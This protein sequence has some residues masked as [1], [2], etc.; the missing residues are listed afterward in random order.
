MN[1]MALLFTL[2]PLPPPT[3]VFPALPL[4]VHLFF[5]RKW[6][7]R[8]HFVPQIKSYYIVIFHLHSV[9]PSF[10]IFPTPSFPS[11]PFTFPRLELTPFL[12]QENDIW[13]ESR[14]GEAFHSWGVIPSDQLG[15]LDSKDT[16]W[17]SVWFEQFS[18]FVA[19]AMC[20]REAR[21]ITAASGIVEP[22][23]S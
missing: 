11:L 3:T 8:N 22:S 18:P 16:G 6:A 15:T 4:L 12:S 7:L 19:A 14:G 21:L 9:S 2:C 5:L 20:K 17:F 1:S 10:H 23:P 13:C